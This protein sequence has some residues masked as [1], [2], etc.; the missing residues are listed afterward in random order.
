MTSREKEQLAKELKERLENAQ[1]ALNDDKD[2]TGA[3]EAEGASQ[4]AEG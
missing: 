2:L 1:F 3:A 4:K